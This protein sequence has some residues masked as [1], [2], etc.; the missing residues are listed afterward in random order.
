[1]KLRWAEM[2]GGSER[3]FSDARSVYELQFNLLDLGYIDKWASI[4]NVVD[5]WKRLKAE[6][7]IVEE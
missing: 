5:L 7:Q 6:A 2:S 1:M 4:L 3:Q